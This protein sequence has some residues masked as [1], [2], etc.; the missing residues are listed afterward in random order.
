MLKIIG[1]DIYKPPSLTGK[2]ERQPFTI[3]ND[4]L[5]STIS[6]WRGAISGRTLP[7]RTDFEVEP[8]A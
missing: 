6:R 3:R 5:I 2:P 4:V 7:E 1:P 8:A